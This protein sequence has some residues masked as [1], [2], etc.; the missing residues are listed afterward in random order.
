[1]ALR[2]FQRDIFGHL[3]IIKR[4]MFV[5]FGVIAH[6]RFKI[7]NKTELI[8]W[9]I[10]KT[11]PR[12][13][14]L[15]VSNHQT[16]FADVT[17]MFLAFASIKNG[18]KNRLGNP[19]YLLRPKIRIYFVAAM[20]TMKSGLL[21][22]IFAQAGGILI[23]RTWREKGKEINRQVDLNDSQKVMNAIRDGW[24]ITFP[25][26]TTTPYKE[27]RKGTA[28][29]IKQAQPIVVPIVIDGF[30]R[31][32]D[33]KGLIIKKKGVKITMKFKPPLVIDYSATAEEILD[34]IMEAIEQSE[35]YRDQYIQKEA[36]EAQ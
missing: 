26:G 32:F 16:Y 21:P 3:L 27:G 30:R 5:V 25:Q 35:K 24:V 29:I 20:E 4:L 28:H 17:L 23:K 9:E 14:V 31:A 18:F 2:I 34:Q 11:L 10:I 1:M 22:R 12:K 6:R 8:G 13:N 7:I 33:K 19:F 15:F 36:T